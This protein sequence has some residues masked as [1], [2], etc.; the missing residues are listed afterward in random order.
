METSATDQ[1][2]RA[3]AARALDFV[4]SGMA[5]GLGSGSTVRPLLGFL[6]ERLR[7]G[8][9]KNVIAVPTSEDTT[10]RCRDL[11]IP[12]VTLG[13]RPEL[14]LAI[15]GADEV[16]PRLDLIK[17]LGGAL[18]REKLVALAAKRFVVVVDE[19][20]LV[21]ELGTRAPL[22]VEVIPFGWSTLVPFFEQLGAAPILRRAPDGSPFVTDNGNFLVDC[23]FAHGI[24]DPAMIARAL[25]KRTGVVEDGLFLRIARTVVVAGAGGVRLLTR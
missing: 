18:L 14:A 7:D 19:S 2:K 3:A 16:S 24:P 21:R 23:R 10:R 9:L 13:D 22:P 17:G 1:L 15:D 25:A 4:E 11:G 5:V 8:A 20:K 6:A 12:L